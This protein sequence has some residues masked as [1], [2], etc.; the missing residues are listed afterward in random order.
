MKSKRF[1][2]GISRMKIPDE[3]S[4]VA[5]SASVVGVKYYHKDWNKETSGVYC[6]ESTLFHL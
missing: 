1:R 2:A 3:S 4:G 5:D 6:P